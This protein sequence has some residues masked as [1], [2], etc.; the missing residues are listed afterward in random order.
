MKEKN[1]P[2]TL[3][4]VNERITT[5]YEIMCDWETRLKWMHDFVYG[6]PTLSR[7][8]SWKNGTYGA[9]EEEKAKYD[10]FKF[11]KFENLTTEEQSLLEQFYTSSVKCFEA[12]QAIYKKTPKLV[13]KAFA[14]LAKGK[15]VNKEVETLN[16]AANQI[17]EL[18][19]FLQSKLA[20]CEKIATKY[21]SENG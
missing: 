7:I 16:Y 9:S 20:S 12:I 3:T 10:I 2:I 1:K 15:T 18:I 21:N 6:K 4:S 5:Q 8:A 17:D 11:T 14:K 19:E 13:D